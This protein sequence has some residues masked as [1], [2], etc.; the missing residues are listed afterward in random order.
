MVQCN[1]CSRFFRLLEGPRCD[2]CREKSEALPKPRSEWATCL[3]CGKSFEFLSDKECLLCQDHSRQMPP[4]PPPPPT[5]S[6]EISTPPLAAI[7]QNS[8][9][10][11]DIDFSMTKSVN[12]RTHGT[13]DGIPYQN[14]Y[15]SHEPFCGD[16][17]NHVSKLFIIYADMNSKIWSQI[18][19]D[20]RQQ[21]AHEAFSDYEN[22][23]TN[24]YHT[25]QRNQNMGRLSKSKVRG[26][27]GP[28]HPKQP[29]VLIN[30]VVR[31]VQT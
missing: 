3:G 16:T 31:I 13:S 6:M 19:Q 4:P 22:S 24:A 12:P 25:S 14:P 18:V 20:L 29:Q 23:Y 27:D 1:G 8:N 28:T 17:E 30:V 5:S 10:L 2:T 21:F 7:N 9:R 15:Q 11:R 26:I